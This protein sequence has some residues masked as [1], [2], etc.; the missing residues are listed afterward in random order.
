MECVEEDMF[1]LQQFTV[2][3][4]NFR[5]KFEHILEEMPSLR[6]QMEKFCS[7]THRHKLDCL[8]MVYRTQ[9]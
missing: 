9:L 5:A 8:A 3:I 6:I 4:R 1:Y 2:L 7:M